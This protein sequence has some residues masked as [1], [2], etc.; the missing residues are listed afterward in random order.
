M[1]IFDVLPIIKKTQTAYARFCKPL[2]RKYRLN[3]SCI[4]IL[5]YIAQNTEHNTARDIC[6]LLGAKSGIVSVS[7]ETLINMDYLIQVD[8]EYDRRVKRL[9]L[10]KKADPLIEEIC[11]VR[12]SFGEAIS[13]G[14]TEDEVNVMRNIA[15]KVTAN[16]KQLSR[17]AIL[18][19]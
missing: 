18:Y 9:V 15:N 10:T 13:C 4:E 19:D 3:Q 7:V 8:D 6:E 1:T 5:L 16:V 14:V 12:K 11:V 2:C 17:E